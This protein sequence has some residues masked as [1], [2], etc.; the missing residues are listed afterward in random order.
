MLDASVE[1]S[2]NI[3]QLCSYELD[4]AHHIFTKMFCIGEGQFPY[5]WHRFLVVFVSSWNK[6]TLR[7]LV[8]VLVLNS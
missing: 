6:A 3:M 4:I 8:R 5:L 1:P 7:M 2:L